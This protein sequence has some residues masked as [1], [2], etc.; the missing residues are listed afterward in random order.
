MLHVELERI[1]PMA[2]PL[3]VIIGRESLPAGAEADVSLLIEAEA[4]ADE[5]MRL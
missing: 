5:A 3:M 2:I 1:S 4:L